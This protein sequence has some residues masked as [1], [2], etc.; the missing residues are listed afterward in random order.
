MCAPDV[1]RNRRYPPIERQCPSC[2]LLSRPSVLDGSS[3]APCAQC[4][5]KAA[6][7]AIDPLPGMT[8]SSYPVLAPRVSMS[9]H[10]DAL[11]RRIVLTLLRM[12]W[13]QA[14]ADGR[15]HRMKSIARL[16][17]TVRLTQPGER[18]VK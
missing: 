5:W 17:K 13:R 3:D 16:G 2:G 1:R 8:Q 9:L 4:G 10:L 11:E 7:T 15:R 12:M 18:F 14:K 6:D